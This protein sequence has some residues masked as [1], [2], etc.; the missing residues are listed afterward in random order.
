MDTDNPNCPRV[1]GVLRLTEK[2]A[3]P[4]IECGELAD[5]DM[6]LRTPAMTATYST[7]A[8]PALLWAI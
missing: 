6:P 7:S 5:A 4:K 3:F 2:S 8:F 1:S